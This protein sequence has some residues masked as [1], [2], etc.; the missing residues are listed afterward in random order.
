MAPFSFA[1]VTGTFPALFFQLLTQRAKAK[2]LVD[3]LKPEK[4][5]KSIHQYWF[6]GG[7]P[8]PWIKRS[9]RFYSLWMN[10]YIATYVYRDV[11]R[12]F[13]GINE[14]RFRTFIQILCGISGNV[15]NYSNAARS[16]RVSQPTAKDYFHIANGTFIWR[17]IPAYT[18]NAVKRLVKHP[19]GYMRDSG[20]LH[21]LLRIPDIGRPGHSPCIG[22][23]MGKHGHRGNSQ[24][25]EQPRSWI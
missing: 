8:E 18:H 19:K 2:E 4:D 11:A 14:N 23:N 1:E 24:R 22:K 6:Q 16:L 10:Q 13:P 17:Q 21:Y 20:L 9:K 7:Y 15:I 25:I 5:I 12:L 3:T